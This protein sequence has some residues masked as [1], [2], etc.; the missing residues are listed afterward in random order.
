MLKTIIF[1][2]DGVIL[3]S[4]HIKTKAFQK[5]F[6]AYPQHLDQI[7]RLHLEHGGMSRFEKFKIIYR[8]YLNLPLDDGELARLGEAFSKLVYQEILRCPFVP[9]AYR[10]LEKYS[11]RYPLFIAS[12]TPESELIDIVRQ[13]QLQKF[14]AGVYGSPRT[15][16]EIL[17]QI[18]T[19]NGLQYIVP[20]H[21][22]NEVIFIGDA[23]TD[24]VA[25]RAVSVPFVGRV[26]QGQANPFPDEGVVALV[27][28]L[29]QLDAQWHLL[30]AREK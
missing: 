8:D 22:S 20:Q 26:P 6:E 13:R 30:G 1:D 11:K 15:K 17:Q 9:G 29:Q 25:A 2:F 16:C 19:E 27:Q 21:M 7:T 12:G 4:V 14:F 18:L 24:Y 10:F 28:D 5:L 23:M 3:E